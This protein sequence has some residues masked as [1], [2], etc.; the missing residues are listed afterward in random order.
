M[1]EKNE[2][3]DFIMESCSDALAVLIV[4]KDGTTI[5]RYSGNGVLTQSPKASS[6]TLDAINQV[7]E[8]SKE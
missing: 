2:F 8:H 1:A 4:T 6:I 7:M 5:A 3:Q